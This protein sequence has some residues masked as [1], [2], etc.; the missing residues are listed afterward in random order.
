MDN[1]NVGRGNTDAYNFERSM[2][3][4]PNFNPE[5]LP[6]PDQLEADPTSGEI[7]VNPN[8]A[9]V[10]LDPS[11]LGASTMNAVK[12]DNLNPA[13]GEV[14]DEGQVGMKSLTEEQII[15]TD[16]N[17]S[18]FQ[19]NGVSKELEVKLDSLKKEPNLYKKSVDFMM[20]AKKSLSVSFA[21]RQYLLGGDK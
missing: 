2:A 12:Y 10:Y 18:K 8:E 20:E 7:G 1:G 3:E 11:L 4:A 21:D 5:N 16:V 15:G 9:G 13:L 14:V 19:K 6:T 17:A